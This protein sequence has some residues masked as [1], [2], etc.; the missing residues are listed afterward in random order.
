MRWRRPPENSC[1]KRSMAD[2]SSPTSANNS[3][4]SAIAFA[5]EVPCTLPS[6]CCVARDLFNSRLS[7][8]DAEQQKLDQQ[9]DKS[10]NICRC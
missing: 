1:G 8:L 7:T 9:F 4:A 6:C 5:R 3:L 2:G 10:L